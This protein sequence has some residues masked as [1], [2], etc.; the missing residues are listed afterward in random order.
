[1]AQKA[2]QFSEIKASA[3]PRSGTGSARA[4]RRE[5][6]VPGIVYGAPGA[7]QTIALDANEL[8]IVINRGKFLSTVFDLD[9]DGSK[10]RV[11]PREVQLDP[12]KDMPIHV[13]FQ[14]V[15]P[16]ARIRVNVPVRFVNEALSPGLKRGGVLNIVR[17]EVEVMAPA[18]KIPDFFEFN[19]EG[20]EI[21]RS[22]HIS[23]TKLPEGVTPTI[24]NRDFTVAT[25]AGHKIEEE[26]VAP[27]AEAVV[28]EGAV[29]AEGEAAAE[30]AP[31]DAK[32]AGG[33]APAGKEA[34][35]AKAPA[36]KEA[37]KP[38][39]SKGGADKGK[40]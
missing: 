10:T 28:A 37:A 5:K 24:L 22:I 3:R 4:A 33:K 8:G 21:G 35:A 31:A 17:H 30:G 19:L 27:G 25:V 39:A 6:R 36:G 34:A 32:A 38:A 9:V 23:A 20:L 18:D 26:A 15:A 2:Q 14:R 7:P 13:D 16:G 40:K 29:P 11:I 12:V 1:M